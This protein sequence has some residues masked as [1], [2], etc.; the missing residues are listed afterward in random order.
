[1]LGVAAEP[2]LRE[3]LAR[4]LGLGWPA[5]DVCDEAVIPFRYGWSSYMSWASR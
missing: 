2:S 5:G 4:T 1:M 3:G